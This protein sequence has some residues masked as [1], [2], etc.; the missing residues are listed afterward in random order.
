[1]SDLKT[2]VIGVS[3]GV[4]AGII[5][6]QMATWLFYWFLSTLVRLQ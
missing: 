1:M 6:S 3:V 2:V 4:F 5:G